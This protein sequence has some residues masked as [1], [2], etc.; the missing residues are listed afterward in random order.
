MI[1]N[2]ENTGFAVYIYP[3]SIFWDSGIKKITVIGN[4]SKRKKVICDTA[5]TKVIL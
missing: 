5:Q 4:T 3:K 2:T 1:K